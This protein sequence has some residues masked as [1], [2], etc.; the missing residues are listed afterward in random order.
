MARA[1]QFFKMTV[2]L[3]TVLLVTACVSARLEIPPPAVPQS[4]F[5]RGVSYT[6]FQAGEYA[7][8]E[9]DATL[10]ETVQPLGV[11][12]VAVVVTCYQETVTAIQIDCHS[13][14]TATDDD[15][16]HVIAV[17]HAHGLRVMLAP[18][19]DPRDYPAHWRGDINYRNDAAAWRDW[20]ASYTA[21]ITHYATLA[22]AT[23]ADAFVIGTELQGTSTHAREWRTVV[24]AVRRLYSGTLTYASN[25]G[26][27]GSVQWWDALDA[28]GVDGYYPLTQR[29]DPTLAQ[30]RAAWQ[31]IVDQLRDLARKWQ[32][33]VLLTEIG[34]Q[35]RDGTNRAPW[36]IDRATVDVQ[37]QATC[38]QAVFDVFANQR[39]LLGIFWWDILPKRDQGGPADSDYTPIGKPAAKVLQRNFN[40]EP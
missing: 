26:E 37:E 21:F 34:Y 23:G 29:D 33:P 38:Y 12:W 1:Q 7:G 31:P 19:I 13:S 9:S 14:E 30:L 10:A 5:E 24:A 16:T 8:A 20:F 35:S 39:W 40:H 25:H 15:L 22:R 6:S 18:H 28:I 11:N 2:S 27:E 36:G 32:R 17:S 4:A 3:V